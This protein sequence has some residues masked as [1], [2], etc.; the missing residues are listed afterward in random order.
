MTKNSALGL[1]TSNSFVDPRNQ[2]WTDLASTISKPQQQTDLEVLRFLP[3]W[4]QQRTMNTPGRT[5]VRAERLRTPPTSDN[6]FHKL[7][8]T[9]RSLEQQDG[10]ATNSN[11]GDVAAVTRW[12]TW[13]NVCALRQETQVEEK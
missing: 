11:C 7:Q 5:N 12:P 3:Q 13:L 10:D 1:N 4:Q 2:N 6:D 9:Q 8:T